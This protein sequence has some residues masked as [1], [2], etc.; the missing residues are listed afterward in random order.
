MTGAKMLVAALLIPV[1][2]LVGL[3]VAAAAVV[4]FA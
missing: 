1:L 4:L 2:I 3:A